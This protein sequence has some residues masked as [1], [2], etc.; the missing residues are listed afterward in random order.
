MRFKSEFASDQ[1]T[2]EL[3]TR[4]QRQAEFTLTFFQRMIEVA[5]ETIATSTV[6]AINQVLQLVDTETIQ[7]EWT[8]ED[9]A[10]KSKVRVRFGQLT[11]F[12][13]IDLNVFK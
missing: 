7:T 1:S 3:V 8:L 11:F 2:D 10:S 6:G 9:G 13:V 4:S 12:A 5:D